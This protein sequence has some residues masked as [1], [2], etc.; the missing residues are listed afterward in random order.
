MR[1]L[2]SLVLIL[3]ALYSTATAQSGAIKPDAAKSVQQS[4]R[5]ALPASTRKADEESQQGSSSQSGEAKEIKIR[6]GTPVDI[7]AVAAVDSFQV[8]PGELLSFRVLIP[9]KVDGLTVIEKNALVTARV[10]EAK[11]GGH[12]GRAGRLSWTMLDVIAVD[13]S[14]LPVQAQYVARANAHKPGAGAHN[15]KGDSH[16]GEIAAKTAAMGAL[17]VPVVVV[18]PVLAPLLLMNGFKR[19]ENAVL[20]AHKR[21]VVFISKEGSVKAKS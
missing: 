15:I 16:S 3:L 5:P 1:K 11:R 19:G 10:V 13:G 2:I 21:F 14:R 18:A 6:A 8:Q 7:E 4:E 20:P 17:L 12:W 9:V